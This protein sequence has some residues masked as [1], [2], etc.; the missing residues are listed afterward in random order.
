[1]ANRP[2]FIPLYRKNHLVKEISFEFKWNPGFAPIQKKKNIAAL[3]EAAKHSGFSPLLEV[4]SKSEN[5]LGQRLSAFSLQIETEIGKISIESAF[6][7]SKVFK[8]GGPYTDIYMKNSRE[9]KQ[10]SRLKSSGN[11]IEFNFMGL[12]WPIVPKTSFYDWLYIKALYPHQEYLKRL[13]EYKGFTDIEFNPEKSINC[14]ARS[15]ALLLSLMK[16]NLLHNAMKSKD[17]FIKLVSKDSFQ[18]KHSKD[19]QQENLFY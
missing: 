8:K 17:M 6:Q 14:Q 7:G 15:C 4:S 9:A 2:V 16:L 11:L 10:D 18:Q 1:M 5:L 3:H 13:Y 12:K 19:L